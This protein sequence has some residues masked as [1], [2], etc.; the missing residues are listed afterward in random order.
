VD[1]IGGYDPAFRGMPDYD[2][3]VRAGLLGPFR[4]V[5]QTLAAY[6]S[7]PTAIT[8]AER[9]LAMAREHIQVLD[10]LYARTDLP[11]ELLAVKLEAYRNAF[12]IAGLVAQVNVPFDE[13]FA[14]TDSLFKQQSEPQTSPPIDAAPELR[15]VEIAGAIVAPITRRNA[16]A[17]IYDRLSASRVGQLKSAVPIEWRIATRRWLSKAGR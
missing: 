12:F 5:P 14:L 4:R 9:G 10:K 1:R 2:F 13:R 16:V 17:A 11:T 8:L 15:P 3:W 7:H 6:R